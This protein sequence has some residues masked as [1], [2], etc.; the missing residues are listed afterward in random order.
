MLANTHPL[1]IDYRAPAALRANR[2]NARTHSKR[3]I[4]QIASSIVQF[5]FTNP[6]LVDDEGQLIAGHGRLKAAQ[7][8]GL[9]SVPTI[10]LKGLSDTQKRALLLADNKIALNAG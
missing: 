7:Q 4:A 6:L 10:E 3:Q 5:G 9:Q 8:L 1:Q 2:H